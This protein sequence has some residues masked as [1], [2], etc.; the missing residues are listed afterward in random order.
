MNKRKILGKLTIDVIVGIIV[1]VI[2]EIMMH[3]FFIMNS[4]I[5]A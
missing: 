5:P 1:S 4:G 2:V 3:I